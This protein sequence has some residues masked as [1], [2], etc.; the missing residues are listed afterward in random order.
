MLRSST[1]LTVVGSDDVLF[2]GLESV[3]AL[4]TVAV[5][6]TDGAAAAATP[7]VRVMVPDPPEARPPAAVHVTT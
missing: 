4:A 2:A 6:V 5:L 3:T 7:T 1:G